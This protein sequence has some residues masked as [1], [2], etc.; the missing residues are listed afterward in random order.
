MSNFSSA[1][2]R[3]KD[4]SEKTQKITSDQSLAGADFEVI[5]DIANHY[6]ILKTE[7]RRDSQTKILVLN[8]DVTK[9]LQQEL[10]DLERNGTS[11]ST[12]NH[13]ALKKLER[14]MDFDRDGS[15]E[16]YRDNTR[17]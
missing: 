14:A 15:R 4:I 11:L 13:R 12:K 6:E 5:G 3:L 2:S 7:M 9:F 17:I 16:Y 1:E 10:R 8:A